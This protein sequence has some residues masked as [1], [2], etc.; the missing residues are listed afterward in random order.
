MFNWFKKKPKPNGPDFSGIDS[1]E[2][3]EEL[4]RRGDLEKMFLMR[5][6]SAARTIRSTPCTSPSCPLGSCSC[7]VSAAQSFLRIAGQ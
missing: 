5:W 3:A 1:R 2:K 4:F 7:A 6:S